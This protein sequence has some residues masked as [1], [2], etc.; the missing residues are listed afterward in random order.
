M[1]ESLLHECFNIPSEKSCLV[2]FRAR[3]TFNIRSPTPESLSANSEQKELPNVVANSLGWASFMFVST[4]PR[5]QMVN[6]VEQVAS[7]AQL[8]GCLAHKKHP[9]P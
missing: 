9:P 6:A 2:N 7:P 3:K 1:Q 8:Q 4:N 5:Y